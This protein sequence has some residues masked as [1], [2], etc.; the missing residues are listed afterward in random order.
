MHLILSGFPRHVHYRMMPAQLDTSTLTETDDD[1]FRRFVT[2]ADRDALAELIRRFLP[3]VYAAAQRQVRDAHLAEDVAQDVFITFTRR[4]RQIRHAAAIG[5]WLLQT[6]RYTAANAIKSE[7]RRRRREQSVGRRRPEEIAMIDPD[8][9]TGAHWQAIGPVLDDAM[10]HLSWSDRT[11]LILRYFRGLSLREVGDATGTSEEGARKRVGRAVERL[12]KRLTAAGATTGAVGTVNLPALLSTHAIETAPANVVSQVIAG[13]TGAAGKAAAGSILYGVWAM[14]ATTKLMIAGAA[15]L[16]V[17]LAGGFVA[18]RMM[19]PD[20]AQNLLPP[21]SARV[22]MAQSPAVMVN[23]P[24]AVGADWEA[25]FNAVYALNSDE[26]VRLVPPPYIAE[27]KAFCQKEW[28][29]TWPPGV[30]P[31]RDAIAIR[32]QHDGQLFAV[33]D[34]GLYSPRGLL[35]GETNLWNWQLEGDPALLDAKIPGDWILRQDANSEQILTALGGVLSKRLGRN[36]AFVSSRQVRDI[37]VASGKANPTADLRIQ[38]LDSRSSQSSGNG[39]TAA[40]LHE[41]SRAA[42]IAMLDESVQVQIPQ[43]DF[44]FV[45]D[46]AHAGQ[47]PDDLLKSLADQT[48]LTFKHEQR[49]VDIWT[50]SAGPG[51]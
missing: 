37:V 51:R 2:A 34:G 1:L 22:E 11:A 18:A 29:R 10:S 27:R 24:P 32:E 28:P 35:V 17:V 12:R 41:F 44:T 30:T 38:I 8:E 36:V 26:I 49:I 15:V 43:F 6:T 19:G 33:S 3:M 47:T 21:E 50:L 7:S 23:A 45:H 4:V 39:P 16:A 40:M 9:E 31:I 20:T 25:K 42:R 46:P 13:A 5:A 14:T 48:G